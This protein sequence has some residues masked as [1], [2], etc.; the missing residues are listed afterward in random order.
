MLFLQMWTMASFVFE[1]ILTRQRFPDFFVNPVL[2]SESQMARI[3]YL[4]GMKE[5]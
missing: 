4:S 2:N 3:Y 5:V 1:Y